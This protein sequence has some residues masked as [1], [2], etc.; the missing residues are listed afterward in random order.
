MT[1]SLPSLPIDP[2][3]GTSNSTS[4]PIA[5][6]SFQPGRLA[7]A[8]LLASFVPSAFFAVLLSNE[9]FASFVFMSVLGFTAI[10]IP[11]TPLMAWRLPRTRRPFATVVLIGAISAPG[12]IGYALALMGVL[13]VKSSYDLL[14]LARALLV[15]APFGACGG[16]IFWL[17]AMWSPP[18]P[19]DAK[20]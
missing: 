5:R 8:L 12:P 11:F 7:L 14:D 1:A 19:R 3:G 17:V 2:P 9:R 16:F 10:A 20:T 6:Y 18:Q 13:T 15:T 4:R